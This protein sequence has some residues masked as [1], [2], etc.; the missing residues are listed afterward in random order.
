MTKKTLSYKITKRHAFSYPALAPLAPLAPLAQTQY[1]IIS[2][3]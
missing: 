1:K 2:H 3:D